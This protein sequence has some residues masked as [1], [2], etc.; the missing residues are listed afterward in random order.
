[1]GM[2][3]VGRHRTPMRSLSE[4][5]CEAAEGGSEGKTGGGTPTT[6]LTC[7]SCLPMA[8]ADRLAQTRLGAGVG[9]PTSCLGVDATDA[10]GD[11][12]GPG[13]FK[14]DLRGGA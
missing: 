14:M 3:T 1:M 10:G 11:M 2:G 8:D 9:V 6:R 7:A 4:L 13:G 5:A 12:M